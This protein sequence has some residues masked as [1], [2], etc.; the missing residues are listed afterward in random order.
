MKNVRSNILIVMLALISI[1]IIMIYSSSAIYAYD[2]MKDSLY[3]L[4]R[5]LLY[6][7]I[8]LIV[9]IGMLFFDYRNLKI[10][11]RP[12]F[13]V[14]VALL[15]SVLIV[16]SEA[17]GAKRWFKLWIFS[18]QPSEFTKFIIILYAADL[19]ERKK[20]KIKNFFEG[21]LPV[22]SILSFSAG[23]IFLQPDLGTSVAIMIIIFL[24]LFVS[25]ANPKHLMLVI[26]L[27]IPALYFAVFRIA[28][29]RNRMLA[30][31]NPWKDPRGT[32]FQIIQSFLALG[33]GG[34]FGVGLGQSKQKLFYLPESHTDFIFSIIGEE[35][36][37]L[38]TSCII[39]LFAVL[40]WQGMKIVFK[41]GDFF[42]SLVSFGIISMIG[43]E[44]CIHVAVATGAMPTKGLPLPFI[45]YGGTSLVMHMASIGIL[46]NIAKRNDSSEVLSL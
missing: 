44:V 36:G 27:S 30:F 18:F 1:G 2:T 17:G 21:F 8:G 34:F 14:S 39:F 28:Y 13:L 38:G 12:L 23:L 20:A 25:G 15:L 24:M 5:H 22:F 41:A 19:I 35:L 42:A 11:A 37:F 43:F 29:R 45:S 33:L 31:L 40:I 3:Y 4:K 10:I 46:L 6:L 32:G 26:L 16:G 9:F 7:G